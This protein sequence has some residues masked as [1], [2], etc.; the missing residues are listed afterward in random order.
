MITI[1]CLSPQAELTNT[2]G[3]LKVSTKRGAIVQ[4]QAF[5]SSIL[6]ALTL[7]LNGDARCA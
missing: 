1:F 3:S 7:S 2:K 5:S 6:G 4:A